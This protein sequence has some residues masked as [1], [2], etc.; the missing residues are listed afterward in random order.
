M[1]TLP[2]MLPAALINPPV[3]TLPPV[4][5]PLAVTTEP[6]NVEPV[7]VLVADINP[8]VNK[9]PPE[10]LAALVMV[11]VALINPAVS[12]LPLVVL[13]V[14]ASDVSVPTEAMFAFALP[15]TVAAYL[16]VGMLNVPVT[17]APGILVNPAPDPLNC[18]PVIVDVAE[19]NPPVNILPPV[20]L[21]LALNT[22]PVMLGEAP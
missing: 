15:D 14:T 21:P 6:I 9:L 10:M 20:T 17:L 11:D 12:K 7:T 2:E 13:A 8:P 1:N 22:L 3:K 5:L 19:I 4:T 18:D 16:V